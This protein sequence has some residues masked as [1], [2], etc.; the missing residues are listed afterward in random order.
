MTLGSQ[1]FSHPHAA[2]QACCCCCCCCNY[3]ISPG[4]PTALRFMPG[5]LDAVKG[6]VKREAAQLL[7][8][9]YYVS[10]KVRG[11]LLMSCCAGLLHAAVTMAC[12]S[13]HN[14][15]SLQCTSAHTDIQLEFRSPLPFSITLHHMCGPPSIT[16]V[17]L[18]Q[19]SILFC[20]HFAM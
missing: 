10:Q 3:Q 13:H 6:T 17:P 4:V 12:Q 7:N 8:K 20:L 18:T 2:Y 14:L 15:P 11:Q 5:L 1:H 19:S 9:I 16:V